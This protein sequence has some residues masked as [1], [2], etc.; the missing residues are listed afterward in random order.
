M[1]RQRLNVDADDLACDDLAPDGD[2]VARREIRAR[3]A[4]RREGR[5]GGRRLLVGDRRH[6]TD[7]RL[8]PS[9][10]AIFSAAARITCAIFHSPVRYL[11]EIR[12]D[13]APHDSGPAQARITHLDEAGKFSRLAQPLLRPTTWLTSVGRLRPLKAISPMRRS[14][15]KG[16]TASA[17]REVTR[18]SPSF[19]SEQSRAARLVTVPMAP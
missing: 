18:I 8:L 3:E 16:S 1:L 2:A 6:G 14:S 10:R 7:L 11:T 12:T 17:T 4:H 5:R 9:L 19:A 13:Q 15:A